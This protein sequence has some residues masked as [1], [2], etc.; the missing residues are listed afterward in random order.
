M[1]HQQTLAP[2]NF[3]RGVDTYNKDNR[4]KKDK[5]LQTDND[6]S[7]SSYGI[8]SYEALCPEDF[9]SLPLAESQERGALLHLS[10]ATA[11]TP[12]DE[13]QVK[14]FIIQLFDNGEDSSQR[15]K[16]KIRLN[17]TDGT[18]PEF[19][20]SL[21]KDPRNFKK[22]IPGPTA[23][24]IKDMVMTERQRVKSLTGNYPWMGKFHLNHGAGN[25]RRTIQIEPDTLA[26]VWWDAEE[27]G[28]SGVF[29]I[30]NFAREFDLFEQYVTAKQKASGVRAQDNW[31]NPKYDKT[32]RPLTWAQKRGLA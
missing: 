19:I 4:D 23:Q 5:T 12:L 25:K 2:T 1:A 11:P 21:T 28:W 29:K 10:K 26:L 17:L 15:Y 20:A 8:A 32:V 16:L 13:D 18:N 27:R 6:L 7:L 30:Q 31:K 14:S 22:H 24:D 9:S 3:T